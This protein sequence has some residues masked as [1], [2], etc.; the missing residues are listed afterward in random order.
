MGA[1]T[2][3]TTKSGSMP[4]LYAVVALS[5]FDR[6]SIA[7]LLGSVARDLGSTLPLVT[8]AA[9]AHFL[10]YGVFQLGHGWLSDRIGRQ[11][12]LKVAL[13]IMGL[14]NIA[15]ALAPDVSFVIV[16]RAIVGAASGGLVP[17]ALLILADQPTGPV[18]ARRQAALMSALG[19]GTAV[20]ALA[21]FAEGP[22]AWR[23]VFGATAAAAIVLML[24]VGPSTPSSVQ[25]SRP[26]AI[27]VFRRS[28]VRFIALIAIPE[29]AAV[30]GFIVFFPLAAQHAG[31]SVVFAAG[32]TAAVGIGMIVGG[33][34]VRR[35][36]AVVPDRIIVAAG[37]AVLAAGYLVGIANFVPSLLAA[38]A[39]V[40]V[41]QTAIHATLQR[42]ATEAAPDARGVS[43][44]LFATGTFGGAGLAALVGAGLPG[45]Y[46]T[47]FVIA[48]ACTVAAG[49]VTGLRRNR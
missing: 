32:T 20:A 18:R 2:T 27:S 24:F 47:L 37:A 12:A 28:R 5:G 9:T 46:S 44:A 8:L 15:V 30:F 25:P 23:V 43:T 17:G 45:Q 3:V 19:L 48:A 11:R 40:G 13:A 49:L 31:A 16:G 21:G 26:S 36:T 39:L 6:L 1:M 33:L 14:A 7:P 38:A 35:M 42:W 29:G 34:I 4:M 22:V 10:S 41:G